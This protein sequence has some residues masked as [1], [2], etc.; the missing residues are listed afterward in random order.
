[1]LLTCYIAVYMD[2]WC[3][4]SLWYKWSTTMP[5]TTRYPWHFTSSS[6][7]YVLYI[8]L[9]IRTPLL[10]TNIDQILPNTLYRLLNCEIGVL[11]SHVITTEYTTRVHCKHMLHLICNA[12]V[13]VFYSEVSGQCSHTIIMDQN[14][15]LT[16]SNIGHLFKILPKHTG[17][18]ITFVCLKFRDFLKQNLF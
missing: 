18:S 8:L 11:D 5:L 1:M 9:S 16:V 15:E 7:Q 3:R 2:I 14:I 4:F 10:Y 13:H 17:E 12:L 6:E